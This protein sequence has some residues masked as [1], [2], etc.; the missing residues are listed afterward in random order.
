MKRSGTPSKARAQSRGRFVAQPNRSA[1]VPA[2]LRQT[3]PPR[4]QRNSSIGSI[5]STKSIPEVASVANIPVEAPVAPIPA[6]PTSVA[7]TVTSTNPEDELADSLSKKCNLTSPQKSRR[8]TQMDIAEE[9]RKKVV[10]AINQT[11]ME[12]D[13]TAGTSAGAIETVNITE[14]KPVSEVVATPGKSFLTPFVYYSPESEEV[15]MSQLH[16]DDDY[17]SCAGD[18]GELDPSADHSVLSDNADDATISTNVTAASNENL[19]TSVTTS[20]DVSV[21]STSTNTTATTTTSNATSTTNTTTPTTMEP[22]STPTRPL[23]SSTANTTPDRP[24]SSL[25]SPS[26]TTP[27]NRRKASVNNTPNKS[28]YFVNC[29]LSSLYIIMIN[30]TLY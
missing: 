28:K 22:P 8:L 18:M 25:A 10:Q 4:S 24:L 30:I 11:W 19:A 20:S 7:A 13:N 14:V 29:I 23:K 3:S 15:D 9:E 2:G 6:A 16:D 5:G 1:A 26:H 21:V 17:Q 27:N 12:V